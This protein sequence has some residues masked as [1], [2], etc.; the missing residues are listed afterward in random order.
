MKKTKKIIAAVAAFVLILFLLSFV[1]AWSGNPISKII[2]TNA[3]KKYVAEKYS[4]LDVEVEKA[5]YNFKFSS[6]MIFFRSP[7]SEDTAFSVYSDSWGNIIRDDYEYEVANN[8]TTWRRLDRELRKIGNKMLRDNL[9]YNITHALFITEDLDNEE[10]LTLLTKDMPLDI[11]NPP[12][13]INAGITIT[14][15]DV[16]YEKMAEVLKSM[17]KLCEDEKIPITSY[18]V[19]IEHDKLV[20]NRD[21]VEARENLTIGLYHIPATILESEDLPTA[22]KE[23]DTQN[24]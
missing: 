3:A 20:S 4:D 1:N 11:H 12:F 15:S 14:D 7:T 18:S 10:L 19:H 21:N 16:S 6:Y 22:L 17:A 5:G 8:F 24:Q 2:A 9:K 23:L 13:D